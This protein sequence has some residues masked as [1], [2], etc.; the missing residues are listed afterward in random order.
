[1]EPFFCTLS[2]FDSGRGIKISEDFHFDINNDYLRSLL[3]S[4]LSHGSPQLRNLNRL[5]RMTR[6]QKQRLGSETVQPPSNLV[7]TTKRTQSLSD[8]V[9]SD[10]AP[11]IDELT[12]AAGTNEELGP[13]GAKQVRRIAT[14]RL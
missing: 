3:A 5:Q 9:E 7:S 8:I 14:K 11:D 12:A 10:T 6:R 2:L 4:A 13:T 1:M